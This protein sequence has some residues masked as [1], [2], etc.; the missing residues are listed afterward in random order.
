MNIRPVLNPAI[1]VTITPCILRGRKPGYVLIK[2]QQRGQDRI[3]FFGSIIQ[4]TNPT[5]GMI[6]ALHPLFPYNLKEENQ[7]STI[8]DHPKDSLKYAHHRIIQVS[9]LL[10]PDIQYEAHSP[11]SIQG[12]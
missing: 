8:N 1:I 4:S 2:D 9:T 7:Q 5:R 3:V 11:K 6:P 10:K 12:A